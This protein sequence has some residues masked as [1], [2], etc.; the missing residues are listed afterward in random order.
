MF[1]LF[2]FATTI[3]VAYLKDGRI[4]DPHSPIAQHFAPA[5]WYLPVHAFFGILALSVAAFQFSNRLRA[6]YLR[7]HRTLGYVY[8]ISVFIS[9]PFAVL[10]A[11]KVSIV[12]PNLMQS[13]AWI[14]TTAIALY[15][16]RSGN[17]VQH[18]RWMIRSYPFAMVFTVVRA[19]RPLPPVARLGAAGR[20]T[21]LWFAIALAA[22]LPNI[23]LE[24]RT[25]FPRRTARATATAR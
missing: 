5:S 13:F 10:V 24:W 23:F 19:I 1:F 20:E 7:L 3:F 14:V 16:V 9:A 18:R 12:A 8:V 17:I 11:M 6:R 21:V 15:C 4:F 22:L 2:F 25:I